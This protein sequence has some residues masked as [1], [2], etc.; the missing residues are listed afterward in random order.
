MAGEL[1]LV[2]DQASGDDTDQARSDAAFLRGVILDNE[3]WTSAGI[4]EADL[5]V[6][7]EMDARCGWGADFTVRRLRRA[8]AVL[9]EAGVDSGVVERAGRWFTVASPVL[10]AI[11]ER[12]ARVCARKGC[13]RDISHLRVGTHYCS[14]RCGN[15]ARRRRGRVAA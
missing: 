12:G 14:E 7:F 10:D 8:L 6:A 4:S 9:T 2:A 5:S 15:L 1:A 3:R 11:D 13:G